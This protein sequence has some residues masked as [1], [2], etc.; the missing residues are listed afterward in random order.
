MP[1]GHAVQMLP[2][3]VEN[4]FTAQSAQALFAVVLP[5]AVTRWPA[6]HV[7]WLTQNVCAAVLWYLPTGQ[8]WH[9]AASAFSEKR[10]AGHCSHDRSAVPL[11][12]LSSRCPAEHCCRFE[13]NV[14]PPSAW[15]SPAPHALQLAALLVPVYFPD[16]HTRHR[17]RVDSA[18]FE[19]YLPGVHCGVTSQYG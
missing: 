8:A 7:V 9:S 2:T 19:S 18:G 6:E 3:A 11:P 1:A 17:S 13:Q 14:C 5:T 4:S 12:A 15:N 16:G 10:P